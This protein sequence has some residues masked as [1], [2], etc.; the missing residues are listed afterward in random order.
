M[1]SGEVEQDSESSF[2]SPLLKHRQTSKSS[3]G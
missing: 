3:L 2:E 1:K